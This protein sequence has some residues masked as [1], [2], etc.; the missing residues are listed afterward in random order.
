MYS[1]FGNEDIEFKDWN[2][3]KFFF[4]EWE[5]YQN[6]QENNKRLG[7][8]T[9]EKMVLKDGDGKEYLTFENWNE[10][11]LISYWYEETLIFLTF[12]SKYIEGDVEFEFENKDET[13]YIQ[14]E[15]G[16]CKVNTGQMNYVEWN[17]NEGISLDKLPIKLKKLAILGNLK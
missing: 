6:Q 8:A 11:K 2:G 3:L 13:G 9:K 14:F 12:I 1:F 5:N 4:D 16:E 10:I 17:S 7:Y 15:N